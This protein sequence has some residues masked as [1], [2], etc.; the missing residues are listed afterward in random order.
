MTKKRTAVIA[1][2]VA[3]GAVVAGAVGSTVVHRRREHHLENV[4]WDV[5]PDDLGP[6]ASFDGTELAVRAA[7][8]AEAPVVVFV[9]GFSLDMTTWHEQWLDLSVDFRCVLMDQRGH[10]RSGRA[11]HGDLSLRSMGR[12]VAAVLEATSPGPSRG[13]RGSQHG[14]DGDPGG[15]RATAGALRAVGGRRRLGRRVLVRPAPRGDGL[16][17]RPRAPSP[18][19]DRGGG[20]PRG[21]SAARGAREPRRPAGRR[22]PADAVRAR[23]APARGRSRRASGR[24]RVVGRLDRRPGR[25]DG[26]GHAARGAAAQGS[27]RSWWW[28][29]TTG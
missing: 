23:R 3:A 11:A 6:V 16:D 17:H 28:G 2:S 24:A 19:L 20:A 22:R 4:L 7:G 25:A 18:R 21:P 29:S 1:G 12:D 10:G 5:P 26:D 15:R 13:A 8:P 14:R 27:G 9:H